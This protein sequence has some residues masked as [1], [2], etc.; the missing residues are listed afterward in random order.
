MSQANATGILTGSMQCKQLRHTSCERE[1]GGGGGERERGGG[2]GRRKREWVS[3]A[4]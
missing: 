4:L 1:G 3:H 2:E